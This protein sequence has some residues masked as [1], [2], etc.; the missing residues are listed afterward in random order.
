LRHVGPLMVPSLPRLSPCQKVRRSP[1]VPSRQRTGSHPCQNTSWAPSRSIV[2]LSS[3]STLTKSISASTVT[4]M[5][6]PCL[7]LSSAVELLHPSTAA[8]VVVFT[9]VERPIKTFVVAPPATVGVP[10]RWSVGLP[11]SPPSTGDEWVT[12]AHTHAAAA[13]L[14]CVDEHCGVTRSRVPGDRRVCVVRLPKL[15]RCFGGGG[16][17]G[18]GGAGAIYNDQ[19]SA[20]TPGTSG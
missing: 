3:A 15:L 20:M 19:N 11:L 17:S 14:T 18:G 8:G 7:A 10:T 6:L 12:C 13:S 5:A 1:S 4:R 2:P 16:G 9:A